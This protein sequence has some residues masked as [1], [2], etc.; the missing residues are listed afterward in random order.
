MI[1]AAF[2]SRIL[3]LA[4]PHM[5]R[6][7]KAAPLLRLHVIFLLLLN[8]LGSCVGLNVEPPFVVSMTSSLCAVGRKTLEG[9]TSNISVALP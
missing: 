7:S 6:S 2:F 3:G 5:K 9:V 8:L 1:K 4:R